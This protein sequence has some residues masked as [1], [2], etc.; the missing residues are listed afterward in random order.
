MQQAVSK[1]QYAAQCEVYRVLEELNGCMRDFADE[2]TG[3]RQKSP[4]FSLPFRDPAPSQV[5]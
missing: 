2:R 4:S 1:K 3:N 5:L